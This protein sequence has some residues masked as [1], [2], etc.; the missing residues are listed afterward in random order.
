MK[1]PAHVPSLGGT[2]FVFSVNLKLLGFLFVCFA[3]LVSTSMCYHRIYVSF[4]DLVMQYNVLQVQSCGPKW[5]YSISCSWG[6][7]SICVFVLA[8]ISLPVLM[9]IL[10]LFCPGCCELWQSR[11]K[12][13]RPEALPR[14]CSSVPYWPGVLLLD[15][16]W[17]SLSLR[18]LHPALQSHCLSFHCLPLRIPCS[19]I[20]PVQVFGDVHSATARGIHLVISICSSPVEN[21]YRHFLEPLCLQE[22]VM[23]IDPLLILASGKSPVMYS[24]SHTYSGTLVDAGIACEYGRLKFHSASVAYL[25]SDVSLLLLLFLI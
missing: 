24:V 13:S 18:S 17:R 20:Y 15:I 3:K 21:S 23:K 14:H 2:G 16:R 11:V 8:S 4:S 5:H 19:S 10:L 9:D 22:G 6:V 1:F 12:S 25:Y 7:V